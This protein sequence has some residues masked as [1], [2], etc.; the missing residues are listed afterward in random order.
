VANAS[1]SVIRA[2]ENASDQVREQIDKATNENV[3][4]IVQAL[5]L[6]QALEERGVLPLTRALV[7][8]GDD[9]LKVI[10]ALIQR[11]EY[12]G[13]IKNLLSLGQ[14]LAAVPHSA[15]NTMLTGVSGGV[16]EAAKAQ[17]DSSFGV[18]DALKAL[19]DPDV[20]RA[21]SF[22]LSFLKGMGQAIGEAQQEGQE[23]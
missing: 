3:E 20:S 1:T 18:Y 17:A 14:V 5:G 15:M 9:V 8:Q 22:G 11:E 2:E 16:K 21:V 4:G 13:A 10:M 12:T 19:K 7:E 23:S 6:L